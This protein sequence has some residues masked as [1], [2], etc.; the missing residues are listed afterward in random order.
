MH[1]AGFIAQHRLTDTAFTRSRK[2]DFPTLIQFLLNHRKGSLQT[3]LDRFF[4]DRHADE[5]PRRY[6]TKSACSQARQHLNYTAF[7]EL[8]KQF[9]E[10]L[11][12]SRSKALK[13]WHGFRLCAVDGSQLRLPISPSLQHYFGCSA[14]SAVAQQTMGLCSV[15]YDVLNEVV[16]DA[17]LTPTR[18]SERD[19]LAHHLEVAGAQDLVL[20]DRGYN[21]FW[22]FAHLGLL[23]KAF[24]I[25]ACT[26][27][28]LVVQAFIQSG[29]SETTVTYK[30]NKVSACHC[31]EFDLPAEPITL[32]LIRV[33]LPNDVEVLI[34]NL[35]DIKRYPAKEFKRLYHQR[36]G[37]ETFFRRAKYQQEIEAMS[38]K[39]VEIVLQ[40]FHATILAANLTASIALAG[41]HVV[42]KRKQSVKDRHEKEIY[43]INFA[44]AYAK[45]KQYGYVL[46][47]RYGAALG[48][49]L[50]QLAEL[51]AKFYNKLRP[52]RSYPRIMTKFNKRVHHMAYKSTL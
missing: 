19:C 36:W 26:A 31:A 27:R 50:L 21:A 18:T 25:R 17:M 32:R 47:L 5:V 15:Y 22:V 42:N 20:L 35:D 2:L 3:E 8:N 10:T 40:D 39:S 14:G 16:I 34:T 52:E 30:P 9:V 6:V 7:I 44:Q 12:Q 37:V 1:D 29:Q 49:Y 28:D 24:C 23:K 51:M 11:Y 48:E 43:Q 4:G 38:G 13:T 33:D 46:W 41:R 45:M